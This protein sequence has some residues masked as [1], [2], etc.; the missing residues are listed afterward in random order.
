MPEV[1]TSAV[2]KVPASDVFALLAQV[3]RNPEWVPRMVTSERLT[4]GPY[5]RGYPLPLCPRPRVHGASD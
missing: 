2:L 4:S 3:E 1:D 5:G